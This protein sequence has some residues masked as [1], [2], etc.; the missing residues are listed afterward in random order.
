MSLCPR[1]HGAID[2]TDCYCRHCGRPLQPR[3]G[4][5]FSHWGL[6][7]QVLCIGPFT[8][9]CVWLSRR[10]SW[11]AKWAWTAGIV[12]F[13]VYLIYGIYKAVLLL[14]TLLAF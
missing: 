14:L 3:R 6:L 1:C 11:A 7:L 13:S 8:L 5:W 4:F 2:E 10:I 9:V 12:L